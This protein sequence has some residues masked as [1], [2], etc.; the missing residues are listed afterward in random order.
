MS[1]LVMALGILLVLVGIAGVVFG[2]VGVPAQFTST[3]M[4]AVTPTAAELCNAGETLDEESGASQFTPG[5]GYARNVR[6]FCVND[7]GVRREVTGNFVTGMLGDAFNSVGVLLIP[8]LSSCILTIG[9]IFTVIGVLFSRRQ[10][11]MVSTGGFNFPEQ[12]V[13]VMGTQT[14]RA[15]T[16]RSVSLASAG[17]LAE[18]LRQLEEA[19]I[20]GLISEDEYQRLRQEALDSLT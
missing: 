4:Q 19:R 7:A 8:L 13:Y 14:P 2:L 9:I 5:Q 1:K 3:I 16:P 20:S 11:R 10:M 15:Q 18:K 17:A 12:Q 6:Y